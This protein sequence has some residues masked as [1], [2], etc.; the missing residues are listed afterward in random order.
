M[1]P[2]TRGIYTTMYRGKKPTIRQF[3]GHG[4]A[5]DTNER[6]KAILKLGGTGLSTAFDLPTLMGRDSDEPISEG[7]VG[8][9][10]VALD[11][12]ADMEDLFDDIPI[13][14]IT[15]SMTINAPAAIVLAMYFAMARKRGIPLERLGGTTQN[16][17]LKEYIAQK[18][19]LFPVDKGVKLVVDTMEFCARDAPRWHPVSISGYHIR[20]AGSNAVQEL[21]YT[22]AD[23]AWY[24]QEAIERGMEIEEFA[25]RLSFFFDVHNDLLEEISKL[26]A[27]RRLWAKIMRD[28]FG[29]TDK[30]SQLSLSQK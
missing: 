24:V 4:L 28:R 20:E 1:F 19:W 27:A 3:A 5:P 26:R 7:Q 16:D 11:T 6:F 17:I 21:A 13:E 14:D 30:R 8:W 29:A 2:F 9:D 15:V 12:L 23:G 25:P 22:L 18:E 10:G